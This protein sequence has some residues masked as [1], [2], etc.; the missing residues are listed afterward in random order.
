MRTVSCCLHKFHFSSCHKTLYLR[1][2]E[3]ISV[4][5]RIEGAAS[6]L[7]SVTDSSAFLCFAYLYPYNTEEKVTEVS[8][9]DLLYTSTMLSK[10]QPI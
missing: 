7:D 6:Y 8:N 4:K 10:F 9:F 2:T 5:R 1:A 3:L